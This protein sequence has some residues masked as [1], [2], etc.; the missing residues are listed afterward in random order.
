MAEAEARDRDRRRAL[1]AERERRRV[2]APAYPRL[3]TSSV[4][5]Q[6]ERGPIRVIADDEPDWPRDLGT[7][8]RLIGDDELA[9]RSSSR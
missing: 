6:P 3:P 7:L 5:P 8:R 1:E 4:A 9:P 2:E